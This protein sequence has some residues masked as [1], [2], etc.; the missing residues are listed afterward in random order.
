LAGWRQPSET[1]RFPSKA[2]IRAVPVKIQ[3]HLWSNIISS[4]KTKAK[5]PGFKL[6]V[7]VASQENQEV[8]RVII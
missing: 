2:A 1:P 3:I 4:Q 5:L 7:G 8:Q 6:T